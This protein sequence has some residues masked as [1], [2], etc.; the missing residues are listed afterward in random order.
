MISLTIMLVSSIMM[1][2]SEALPATGD[3]FPF[4]AI[5]IVV[6]LAL[7]AIIAVTILSKKSGNSKNS[8]KK[9]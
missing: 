3:R 1:F 5:G 6:A 9:K 7:I 8:K 4:V 2:L